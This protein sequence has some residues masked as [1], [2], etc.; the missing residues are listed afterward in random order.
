MS[1]RLGPDWVLV[2]REPAKLVLE[3]HRGVELRRALRLGVV[4]VGSLLAGLALVVET[5]PDLEV[6][7]FPVAAML[8]FVSL[9]GLASGV[10]SL[11]LGTR[12]VQL[13]FTPTTVSGTLASRGLL[14]DLRG[15]AVSLPVAQ[16]QAVQLLRAPH[17]G[18]TLSLFEVLLADGR[19]LQGPE[20]AS[21]PGAVDPLE[22]VARAAANLINRPL[23]LK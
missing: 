16:V 6:A 23:A 12:G 17:P 3:K 19:A 10:R 22:A 18:L 7:T 20:V 5:P 11:V 15:R 1:E 13:V 2:T 4:M 14:H 8:G 21:T 9:L